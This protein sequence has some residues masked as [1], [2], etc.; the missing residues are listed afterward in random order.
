ME[1]HG[2]LSFFRLD[3]I[4]SGRFSSIFRG[5]FEGSIDVAI[6]RILL[7]EYTVNL[8]VFRL[9][10]QHSNILRYYCSEQDIEFM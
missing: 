3:T 2:K 8:D 10:Q 7:K 5:K 9:V 1:E 4:G 6:K